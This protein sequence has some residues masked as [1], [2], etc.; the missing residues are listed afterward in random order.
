MTKEDPPP[1]P[2]RVKWIFPQDLEDGQIIHIH[3]QGFAVSPYFDYHGDGLG[4]FGSS[5][6]QGKAQRI[7][8]ENGD[9]IAV[10]IGMY[11][12]PDFLLDHPRVTAMIEP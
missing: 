8:D 12:I 1:A 6:Y 10:Q 5:F 4:N 11:I 7:V 3:V 9:L 2:K